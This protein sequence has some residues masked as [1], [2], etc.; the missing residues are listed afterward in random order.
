MLALVSLGC[1]H[2][3]VLSLVVGLLGPLLDGRALT[4][5]LCR[6]PARRRGGPL[7]PLSRPVV[8]RNIVDAESSGDARLGW[9][10]CAA[11]R[12]LVRHLYSAHAA[13][14]VARSWMR[15]QGASAG[16]VP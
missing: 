14:G 5:G 11:V 7:A 12:A 16:P 15:E 4:E 6:T 3:C 10:C 8:R 1:A 2:E 9:R 13:G